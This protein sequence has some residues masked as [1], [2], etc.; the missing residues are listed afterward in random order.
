MNQGKLTRVSNVLQEMVDVQYVSGVTC[1]VIQNGE[2]QCYY[3]AGLRDIENKL[4][5]KRDT[6]FRMYS[7]TKPVTAAA[8]MMLLE[9]GKIDLLEPVSQYLPG[10]TNQCVFANGKMTPAPRPVLIRDLLNMTSGLVYPGESSV[11]EVRTGRLLEEVQE[12]MTSA[13]PLTTIEIINR[14][15]EIPL[16]FNP[17]ERWQYGMS[18]DAL[19]AVIETASGMKFSE[20][21][22]RRIFEPLD[23]KDTGFYVP[24]DKQNRLAKVYDETDTGLKECHFPHLAVQNRMEFPPAFESGGA[25]LVSTIDDYAAF[26]QMLLCKGSYQGKTLLSP[27]T[28]E[29]MTNAHLT[30]TQQPFVHEWENLPGYTYANLLRILVDPGAAVTFG[31]KGEYGWDGWLGTYMTN[32]PAHHLTLLM[33]Q[34]KT[35]S[36]TTLYTRKIRNILFSSLD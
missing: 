35:N 23:M 29:F 14:L 10:F 4:P 25:G 3:E 15:G 16:A 28:V 31:S 32:D 7:M 13:Q 24:Q 17:G 21:L 22:S 36:G 8:A 2:E 9:E 5:M 6:I 11:A 26:T 12:K 18:A 30:D 19:G 1:M 27:K 33:M 34:Q 20:F